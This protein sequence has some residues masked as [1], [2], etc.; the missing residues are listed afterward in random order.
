VRWSDVVVSRYLRFNSDFGITKTVDLMPNG[1]NIAVTKE[2]RLQYIYLIS[3]YRLSKQIKLQSE[4]F[5]EG[6]SEIIDPKWLKCVRSLSTSVSRSYLHRRMFNQQEL[7]ILIG[8]TDSP[9]DLD[10]L[11][12]NTQ[13]GGIY[14]SNHATII[15]FWRVGPASLVQRI[16]D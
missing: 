14:D 1:S 6:L 8:G 12:G 11:Q 15:S 7:Q 4:A 2:N 10:D 13:Y 3:H 9:V 16:P 5:F